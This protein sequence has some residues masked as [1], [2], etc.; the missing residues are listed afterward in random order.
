[1][2]ILM[3]SG[4]IYKSVRE[5]SLTKPRA[6]GRNI[7]VGAVVGIVIGVLIWYAQSSDSGWFGLSS[8]DKA[9]L[10]GFIGAGAGCVVGAVIAKASEKKYMINGEW[11]NLEEMK[12]ALQKNK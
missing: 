1:M 9:V 2:K 5:I 12:E 7:L 3:L 10:G 4:V 6:M 11:K 8:E